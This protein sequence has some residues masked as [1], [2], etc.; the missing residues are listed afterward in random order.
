MG[1][2]DKGAP[3]VADFSESQNVEQKINGCISTKEQTISEINRLIARIDAPVGNSDLAKGVAQ[4]YITACYDLELISQEESL[5]FC[6]Q[7]IDCARQ[8]VGVA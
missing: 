5:K 6:A 7:L 2:I 4:G 3:F 8:N 1:S